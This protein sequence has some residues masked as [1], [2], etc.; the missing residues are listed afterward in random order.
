MTEERAAGD[1][2]QHDEGTL[3]LHRWNEKN[4][5]NELPERLLQALLGDSEA[6]K[7]DPCKFLIYRGNQAG[8]VTEEGWSVEEGT[9]CTLL[10]FDSV[11]Q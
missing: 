2:A 5:E 11:N 10:H 1:A 4:S 9:A 8:R 7:S 3:V 6:R